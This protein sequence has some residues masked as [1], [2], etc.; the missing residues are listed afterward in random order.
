M[1]ARKC[2]GQAFC[3]GISGEVWGL[4]TAEGEG[5]GEEQEDDGERGEAGVEAHYFPPSG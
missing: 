1:G 2:N 5:G 3:W 4:L